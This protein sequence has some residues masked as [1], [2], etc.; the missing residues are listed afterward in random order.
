MAY[1]IDA[2][3]DEAA[4]VWIATSAEVP[5]LCVEAASIETLIVIVE[6]VVP[7]LPVANG[8]V[9]ADALGDVPIRVVAGRVTVAHRAA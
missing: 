4:G 5:G 9:A 7:E 3:W 8:V 6:N 1:R 2:E